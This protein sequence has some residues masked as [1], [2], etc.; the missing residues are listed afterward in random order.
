VGALIV[1]LGVVLAVLGSIFTPARV[2][3]GFGARSSWWRAHRL[4][5]VVADDRRYVEEQRIRRQ[6]TE[7]IRFLIDEADAASQLEYKIRG[8]T[9]PDSKPK[10]DE[11]V[12]KIERCATA[13][14]AD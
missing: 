5:A 3:V 12:A 11:Y 6:V 14:A 13:P 4:H 8:D 10:L 9:R 1:I 2:A 7:A